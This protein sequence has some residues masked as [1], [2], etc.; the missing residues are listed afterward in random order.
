MTQ[1]QVFEPWHVSA[2]D[3]AKR[4]L[5]ASR[6]ARFIAVAATSVFALVVS[7]SAVWMAVRLDA[8]LFFLDLASQRV[9][10]ALFDSLGGA[11]ATTFGSAAVDTLRTG[12]VAAIAGV[13][14]FLVVVVLAA[15]GLRALVATAHRRRAT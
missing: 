7:L 12:G 1:V 6:T 10:A 11:I 3:S 2:L 5:P 8:F 14:S 9:R 4:W 15:V 13:T